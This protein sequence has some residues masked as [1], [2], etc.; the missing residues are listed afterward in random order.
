MR[1]RSLRVVLLVKATEESD[2]TG[3]LIPF[4]DR[5]RAAREALRSAAVG[6]EAAGRDGLSPALEQALASRAERLVQ[7]LLER[8]PVLREVLLRS[9]PPAWVGALLLAAALAAGASLSAFDGSRRINILAPPVLGLVLWNL[10]VYLGLAD[11]RRQAKWRRRAGRRAVRPH[12][13][14]RRRAPPRAAARPDRGGR[15]DSRRGRAPFRRGLGR[16]RRA[17]ARQPSAALVPPRG[18]RRRGGPR[19]RAVP[20]RP[21]AA[22]RGGLGEHLPRAAAG[23]DADRPAVRSASRRWPASRCRRRSRRWRSCAGTAPAAAAPAAPWIHLI[24]LLLAALVVLPRLALA[25][26]ARLAGRRLQR[27]R[28]PA[29]ERRALRPRSPSALGAGRAGRGQ[30]DAVRLRAAAAHAGEPGGGRSREP[31]G[32]ARGRSCARRSPTATRAPSRPPSTRTR[33]ASPGRVL[34]MNLAATPETENHGAAIVAARDHIAARAARA[35]P[36]RR[37]RRVLVRSR[38]SRPP[39]PRR[40]ARGAARGCGASSSRPTASRSPSRTRRPSRRRRGPEW[41]RSTLSLISHTNIGKTTLAR[42]LLRRDVGDIRDGAHVTDAATGYTLIEIARGRRAAALGHPGLRRQRAAA[43]A[44][45][46]ERQPGRLAAD[47]GLGPLRRPA[48]LQQPA[49]GAQR[50]RRRRRGA[51]PRQRRGGPGGRPGTSTPRCRSSAGPASR[52]LVLRQPARGAAPGRSWSAPRS[53]AGRAHLAAYPW[54]RGLLAF[55][56][57]A[58]CW[59]Q[60][61]ALLERIGAALPAALPRG[62][63]AG[64]RRPGGRAT[65]RCSVRSVDLLAA[66]LAAVAARRRGGRDPDARR[67]GAEPGCSRSRAASAPTPASTARCGRSRGARRRAHPRGD[68][69]ADRAARPL[70]KRGGRDPLARRGRL[71]RRRRRGRGQGRRARR[72]DLRRARRPRRGPRRRRPDVRRRRAGR[73]PARRRGRARP[74]AGLQPD[75]RHGDLDGPLERRGADD[76]R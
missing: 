49:R 5:E 18:G 7:P 53:S 50:P 37:R 59:V 65:K 23:Q 71:R 12:G 8:H 22:L 36:A 29:R 3:A 16:G 44:A 20:A 6:S 61:H 68:G 39:R 57:F 9:G 60:E 30:R 45:A 34:L 15:H 42:T 26:A 40:A 63:R 47:A 62:V 69:R 1:E 25:A 72:R 11:R 51:L 64:S 2:R 32:A 46:P 31:S 43:A 73:R 24:A 38:A 35:A 55:D 56:A 33:T 48:L 75:A 41:R 21:R 58:R 10:L 13:D 52:S 28:P 17:A 27:R 14:A 66:E 54:V 19:R 67:D 76:A 74:R 4:G 70:G